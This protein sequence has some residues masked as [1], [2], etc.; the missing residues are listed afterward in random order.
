MK[1]LIL[2]V[3]VGT[4]ENPT[5]DSG[6]QWTIDENKPSRLILLHTTNKKSEETAKALAELWEGGTAELHC[7]I[8]PDNLRDCIQQI[9]TLAEQDPKNTTINGFSG[10]KTMSA[11]SAIAAIEA[12]CHELQFTTGERER[13]TVVHGTETLERVDPSKIFQL[14]ETKLAKQLFDEGAYASAERLFKDHKMEEEALTS[15]CL[16]CWEN[17]D[18]ESARQAAAR[19]EKLREWR[20]RLNCLTEERK[21]YGSTLVVEDLLQNAGILL[22]RGKLTDSYLRIGKAIE[23][24]YKTKLEIVMGKRGP[25]TDEDFPEI[26]GKYYGESLQLE[27]RDIENILKNFSVT[28]PK[29]L[30]TIYNERSQMI[31]QTKRILQ[32]STKSHLIKTKETLVDWIE[33]K[34]PPLRPTL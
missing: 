6:L 2:T 15:Q 22:E 21:N 33:I 14:R 30:K 9:K 29:Q 32:E 31:H 7:I 5:V 19:S 34:T 1:T 25:Y 23:L 26:R 8:D 17:E 11:S 10:T 3:G 28:T 27:M 20:Q 24:A 13:G 4:G 12:E 18:F 16:L